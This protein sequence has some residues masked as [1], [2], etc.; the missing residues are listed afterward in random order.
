MDNSLEHGI[1]GWTKKNH[2]YVSRK[3]GRNGKWQYFYDKVTSAVKSVASAVSGVLSK[4]FNN[5]KD[6]KVDEIKVTPETKAK[7]ETTV[8]A[9]SK[10]KVSEIQVKYK[11]VTMKAY[12]YI[13]KV[14]TSNGR[15]R[16]FYTQE[17]Y[18]SYQNRQKVL[19][20][21][22]DFMQN[23]PSVSS[24]RSPQQAAEYVD[25]G[26]DNGNCGSCTMAFELQ[27]RGYDVQSSKDIDGVTK[28]EVFAAFGMGE[29]DSSYN[30][31]VDTTKERNKKYYTKGFL[32]LKSTTEDEKLE[33]AKT[34]LEETIKERG[35]DNQRGFMSINW[36]KSDKDENG[37]R[38]RAGG[39]HIFNYVVTN[40]EVKFYDAQKG[41]NNNQT[42][43]EIDI[44]TY[45]DNT[46]V[47][48]HLKASDGGWA[49]YCTVMRVDNRDLSESCKD[50]IS[51]KSE[52]IHT[53][54]KVIETDIYLPDKEEKHG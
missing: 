3:K 53:A 48:D 8:K 34:D 18:A 10:T 32:G 31:Y 50:Y 6:V 15:F 14:P 20:K 44:T 23:V 37:I 13:A 4:V 2:K 38:N 42:G 26:T 19:D 28:D 51:Y 43:G 25:V 11:K 30:W 35:G 5:S 49:T 54:P 36:T 33:M 27:M 9:V 24:K 40:G 46:N 21:D 17:E 16:Y 12:K 1:F 47:V 39:G 52:E 45:L 29:Y 22:Y 41:E 7:V